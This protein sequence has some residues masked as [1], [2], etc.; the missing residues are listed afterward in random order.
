MD[1]EVPIEFIKLIR[2]CGQD[3]IAV[4]CI[5]IITGI[6]LYKI[7]PF[8]KEIK[9]ERL[10][11]DRRREERKAIEHSDLQHWRME[12]TKTMAMFVDSNDRATTSVNA[13]AAQVAVCNA[14]LEENKTHSAKMGEIVS[15]IDQ[16]VKDIKTAIL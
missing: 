3:W 16:N 5:S 1:N 11:I 10:E 13:L 2:E 6:F 8:Y 15:E 4:I 7:A 14:S 12:Q 9:S